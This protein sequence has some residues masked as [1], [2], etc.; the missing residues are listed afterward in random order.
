M[1][2]IEEVITQNREDFDTELP[3]EMLWN[4]IQFRLQKKQ[5]R[6][7]WK[8]YLAAAS[9]MLFISFTWLI[10]NTKLNEKSD[11]TV[12]NLPAEVTE[13]QAEFTSLIEIKKNELIQ[14][15]SENPELVND[16]EH[17][18]IELQKNYY[19]LLPQLKD[20]DKK[21]YVLQAVI[22]NLQLQVDILNRQLEILNQIKNNSNNEKNNYIQL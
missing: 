21:D 19:S 14:R 6:N 4:T 10:E 1:K 9:V 7:S 11:N 2:R 18:L 3:S 22:E 13:A 15:K 8:P 17:Q 12:N 5:Q 20:H 16:F